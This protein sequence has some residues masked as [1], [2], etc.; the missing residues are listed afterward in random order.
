M[1]LWFIGTSVVAVAL[2]FRSPVIDY[3]LIA[4]GSVLP[5]LEVLLGRPT[6][7]HTLVLPVL[8]LVLV[9]VVASG[10]RLRQRR[11]L[12]VPIGMLFHLV[13]D[14]TW[15][16]T[17][18]FW[19]PAAGLSFAD[20]SLP[21]FGGGWWAVAVFELLGAGLLVWFV[22]RFD[23]RR[24]DRRVVFLRSGHLGRDLLS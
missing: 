9:M 13:F 3:R 20:R 5:L 11:W 17:R 24:P 23:L 12:G 4:L 7:L 8:L 22:R 21:E 18:L 1:L 2:I 6:L 10:H 16:D 15:T 14:R 19:W